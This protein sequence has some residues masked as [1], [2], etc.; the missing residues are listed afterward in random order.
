MIRSACVRSYRRERLVRRDL[1]MTILISPGAQLLSLAA[2]DVACC[3]TQRQP[4]VAKPQ[5]RL[6]AIGV[7][8]SDVNE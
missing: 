6:Q 5:P 4:M 1:T 8:E 2:S 7:T 3:S